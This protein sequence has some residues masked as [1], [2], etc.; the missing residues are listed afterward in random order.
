MRFSRRANVLA[1]TTSLAACGG[2]AAPAPAINPT[3]AAR[4]LG[5]LVSSGTVVAPAFTIGA[6]SEFGWVSRVG[7]GRA[8]LRELDSTIVADLAARGVRHGWVFASDLAA[9]YKRN[10]GYATDPYALAEEPLLGKAF[11]AGSRLPEPLASQLRT[12]IALHDGARLVLLPLELSFWPAAGVPDAARAQLKVALVD[13]RAS[14]AVWVGEVRSDSASA[15]P[16]VL[17]TA[18]AEHLVDMIVR[19]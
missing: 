19:R 2:A 9:S 4:P 16:R 1:L 11:V 15:D 5:A 8:V 18:V 7:N 14:E 6:P 12:M 10:P 17:A 3:P 13:P